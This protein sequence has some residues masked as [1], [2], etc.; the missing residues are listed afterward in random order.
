MTYNSG[1]DKSKF[2][3]PSCPAYHPLQP[4]RNIFAVFRWRSHSCFA[5]NGA[6]SADFC[7]GTKNQLTV[8]PSR[9]K[10]SKAQDIATMVFY[11]FLTPA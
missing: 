1:Y 7:W 3:H 4:Q 11:C 6:P 2:P 10:P 5:R 9:D 8:G